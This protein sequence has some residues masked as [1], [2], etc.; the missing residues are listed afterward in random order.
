M[1]GNTAYV[2]YSCISYNLP[3]H[4]ILDSCT[5]VSL[6]LVGLAQILPHI[7][8]FPMNTPRVVSSR[9]LVTCS[10]EIFP[11]V[12]AFEASCRKLI[13]FVGRDMST[14]LV[15]EVGGGLST[16]STLPSSF[17]GA[18]LSLVDTRL[19]TNKSRGAL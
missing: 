13:P 16:R 17:A 19:L 3:D 8:I 6:D 15:D 7:V 14:C 12:F 9:L 2:P 5:H 18:L 11:G 1:S 4:H 10:D